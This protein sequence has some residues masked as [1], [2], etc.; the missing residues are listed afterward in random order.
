MRRVFREFFLKFFKR[1]PGKVRDCLIS[2]VGMVREMRDKW[3]NRRGL[4]DKKHPGSSA[5]RNAKRKNAPDAEETKRKSNE[6]QEICFWSQGKQRTEK[7]KSKDGKHHV[8]KKS[9]GKPLKKRLWR[10]NNAG[11]VE[12]GHEKHKKPSQEK[13]G[14]RKDMVRKPKGEF[15]DPISQKNGNREGN[16]EENEVAE[17]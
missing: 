14:K 17:K 8:K 16:V 4:A 7:I 5:R 12:V 6:K 13:K 15:A 11:A 10:D 3:R 2:K 9:R 1:R